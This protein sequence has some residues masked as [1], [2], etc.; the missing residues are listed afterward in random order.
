MIHRLLSVYDVGLWETFSLHT[1][2]PAAWSVQSLKSVCDDNHDP[3][4]RVS[5]NCRTASL[6]GCNWKKMPRM[7]MSVSA[8]VPEDVCVCM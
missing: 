1:L 3:D 5:S 2:Q 7:C 6:S 8:S 4:K